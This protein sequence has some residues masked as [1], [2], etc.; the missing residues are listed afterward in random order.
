MSGVC[1]QSFFCACDCYSTAAS[2]F[3]EDRLKRKDLVLGV[4]FDGKT[5]AYPFKE[6]AGRVVVNGE[7][8]RYT[9][10]DVFF[11]PGVHYGI[12]TG[13]TAD[14]IAQ[15]QAK[16]ITD[17]RVLYLDPLRTDSALRLTLAMGPDRVR[18]GRNPV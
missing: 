7:F 3:E 12:L 17:F 11:G 8:F 9:G 16:R 1:G 6:L 10:V 15:L 5:K 13:V 18:D 2:L 4:D 14:D